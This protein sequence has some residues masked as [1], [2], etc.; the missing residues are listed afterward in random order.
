MIEAGAVAHDLPVEG[1]RLMETMTGSP[2]QAGPSG[3]ALAVAWTDADAR[4]VRLVIDE[5]RRQVRLED[6]LLDLTPL[7]FGLL[8]TLA[9]VPGRVL[10]RNGLLRSRHLMMIAVS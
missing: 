4:P 6:R 1:A 10:R 5:E 3:Q 7:E 9:A 8:A 2:P